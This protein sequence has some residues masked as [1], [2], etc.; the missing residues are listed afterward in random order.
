MTKASE[1]ISESER[2]ERSHKC[3]TVGSD[4]AKFRDALKIALAALK[5]CEL[6]YKG[7]YGD[8]LDGPAHNALAEIENIF[9]S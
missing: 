3:R 2:L 6:L 8:D 5:E 9:K 7:E 1:A 4:E